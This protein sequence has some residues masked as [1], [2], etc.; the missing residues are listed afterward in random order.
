MSLKWRETWARHPRTQCPRRQR[1]DNERVRA[2]RLFW[3]TW[4]RHVRPLLDRLPPHIHTDADLDWLTTLWEAR[5]PGLRPI[6]HQIRGS[7][8]WVRFHSL[9]ESKRY[10]DSE[11]EYGELLARH[12]AVLDSLAEPGS[13][14]LVVTPSWSPTARARRRPRSVE[15][16]AP[17]AKLWMSIRGDEEDSDAWFINL[18]VSNIQNSPLALDALLR[19]VADSTTADVIISAQDL[20]WLYHP[21]GGGADVI[22]PSRE[23]RDALKQRFQDWLPTNAAG[24]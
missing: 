7:E 11:A 21:Y 8:R 22:A 3:S 18:F 9:P 20:D 5:F 17:N 23:D 14:M 10:A 12:H 15:R 6:G 4:N 2:R 19:L 1:E 13:E 16:A 24:L